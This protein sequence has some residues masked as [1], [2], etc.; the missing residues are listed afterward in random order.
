MI[1]FV[2]LSDNVVL[3]I[4]PSEPTVPVA[5]R[6]QTVAG[7]FAKRSSSLCPAP[8]LALA[9]EQNKRKRM[10]GRRGSI[11]NFTAS[12]AIRGP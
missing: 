12:C 3:G 11:L 1:P 2:G 8:A 10:D 9:G 7:R 4:E 5:G 6:K